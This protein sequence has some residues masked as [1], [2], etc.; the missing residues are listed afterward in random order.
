MVEEAVD[1]RLVSA[2]AVMAEAGTGSSLRGPGWVRHQDQLGLLVRIPALPSSDEGD[3]LLLA[4]LP[5]TWLPLTDTPDWMLRK[6]SLNSTSF[7]SHRKDCSPFLVGGGSVAS[8]PVTWVVPWSTITRHAIERFFIVTA[9]NVS[10]YVRARRSARLDA[11]RQAADEPADVFES[12][13]DNSSSSQ[14]LV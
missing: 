7:T 5:A 13:W 11:A 8:L 4:A 14:I 1:C 3:P 12:S 2:L 10:I 6:L 9:L